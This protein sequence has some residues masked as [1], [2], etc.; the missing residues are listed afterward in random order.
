MFDLVPVDHDPFADPPFK[1]IPVD[2]DPFAVG[3]GAQ[4]ADPAMAGAGTAAPQLVPVDHD[5]FAVAPAGAPLRII[6]HPKPPNAPPDNPAGADG[7]DDW[8]VPMADGYPDD[9]FVPAPLA[10]PGPGQSGPAAQSNTAIPPLSNPP[11]VRPDP[12]AAYRSLIPASRAG[13]FAWHPPIFPNS[14]G[15]FP[16]PA[17]PYDPPVLPVGGLFA[18]IGRKLAASVNGP[19]IGYG[20]FGSPVK[21]RAANTDAL[22]SI[23]GAGSN[24]APSSIYP[25][26]LGGSALPSYL[27]DPPPPPNQSPFALFGQLPDS[28]TPS[29]FP[30]GSWSSRSVIPFQA[31]VTAVPPPR[32]IFFN[33][34][35]MAWDPGAPDRNA[36]NL[37]QTARTLGIFDLPLSKS[38]AP[39]VSPPPQ[40]TI[41]PQQLLAV[42]HLVSP[43]LVDY[44]T[45]TLPPA[46]P[47]P[48]TP[49]RSRAMTV[50]T[51]RARPSRP[52]LGFSEDWEGASLVR[53]RGRRAPQNE[54][55]LRQRSK[56]RNQ[57]VAEPA[58]KSPRAR[59]VH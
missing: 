23:L 9:W 4:P 22:P 29:A 28:T 45:K 46:P 39:V 58:S 47:L 36:A 44:F 56:P 1:L 15:Q 55:P 43:N 35:P 54:A 11:A 38:S 10:T 6:V 3:P 19:G 52:R 17:P 30:L 24:S 16:P 13:A 20:L 37:D 8:F 50:R 31:P 51:G 21:L 42:A 2:H 41:T 12:S 33:Q 32:S 27:A 7:P 59:P 57:P 5:P 14:A 48:S 34:A 40:L 25:P 49:A 53:L 26:Y 18:G